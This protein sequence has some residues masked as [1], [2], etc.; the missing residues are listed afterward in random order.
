MKP[1]RDVFERQK[2][3]TGVVP[4]ASQR[5]EWLQSLW[6]SM[7]DHEEDIIEALGKDLGKPREEVHLHEMFPVKKEIQYARRHLRGWMAPRRSSTP[8]S[9]VGTRSYVQ[10]DPKGQV[11]VI[12]PWNFPV[13]LTLRPLV[14]ALA[15]GN[16]VVVKPSEHTP[17]TSDVLARV[18]A[19]ALPPE[20]ATVVQGGPEVSSFLT[21]L[22]FQHICFTG[23]TH[24][25]Q[26]VMKA[27]AEHL[28]SITLELGG[29]SPAIV[30]RTAHVLD[31]SRRLAWG[32]CLNNGQ[33][34]IAPDYLLVEE[35]IADEFT[36]ALRDQFATMYGQ[37]PEE[38]LKNT[39]RSTIVNLAQFNRL[40]ALVEDAIQQGAKVVHGGTWDAHTL[41]MAPTLLADVHMD[42]N[43]MKEEIFGP[44]LPILRWRQPEEADNILRANPHP[45]AMYV[46]SK[47]QSAIQH[48]TTTHP[49]GTTG[50]NEVVLQV[51]QPDLPFG[52]I[53]TSGMGRTGG[54][55]GFCQ[56]S[57][58]RSVVQQR[59]RHNILPLTFPPFNG[60]SI[61]LSRF[62]QRWL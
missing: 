37:E 48:W 13:T 24:I 31:A 40:V 33:V 10:Q 43:I 39:Q 54:Y 11:L 35:A 5:R 4:T 14:S 21:S 60:A 49:A 50:I 55:G 25:G 18:V 36:G 32:K 1:L 22:P 34:C 56:F 23:G 15:A 28:T 57:N 2:R 12:A 42:M 47:D 19:K 41:R 51:A 59:T 17:N 6:S 26:K 58:A 29:K 7:L 27:A 20:V 8:I 46:F 44:I 61:W 16:R 38:Q 53:Q 9:M 52:G 30:D 62:V 3:L 45:L